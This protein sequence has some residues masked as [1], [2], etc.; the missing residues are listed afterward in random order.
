[1]MGEQRDGMLNECETSV[2]DNLRKRIECLW[3]AG[4]DIGEISRMLHIE[5]L[6]I[7]D[8]VIHMD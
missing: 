5:I 3:I 7:A 8:V 4:Y 2:S 6:V 1:M